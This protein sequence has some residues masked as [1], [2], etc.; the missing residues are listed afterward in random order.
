MISPQWSLTSMVTLSEIAPRERRFERDVD[1]SVLGLQLDQ[2]QPKRALAERHDGQSAQA[3]VQQAAFANQRS[4]LHVERHVMGRRVTGAMH[5]RSARQ[6]DA[7]L[8]PVGGW[9]KFWR[10][11]LG[12]ECVG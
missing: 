9:D 10:G 2:L 8:Q 6:Q 11:G 3:D 5:Q 4:P 1:V 12:T 7:D